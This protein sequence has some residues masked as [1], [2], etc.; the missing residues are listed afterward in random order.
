MPP[1]EP[2]QYKLEKGIEV[3]RANDTSINCGMRLTEMVPQW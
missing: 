2:L 3:L 1:P